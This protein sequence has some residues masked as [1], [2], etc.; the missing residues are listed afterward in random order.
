MRR[1]RPRALR[2]WP[3][4]RGG[5]RLLFL[6]IDG[7]LNRF[8]TRPQPDAAGLAAWLDPVHL[9]PLNRALLATAARVVISSSWRVGKELAELAVLLGDFGVLAP[10]VGMTP[11][12]PRQSRAD[13]IAAWL[14]VRAAAPAAFAIVDDELV[15]E[16]GPLAPHLVRTSRLSGLTEEHVGPLVTRLSRP[17]G[18]S[19]TMLEA[20]GPAAAA[21]AAELALEVGP[22]HALHGARVQAISR[23]AGEDDVLF[24]VDGPGGPL[25]V[26]HLTW[27][28]TREHDARWPRTI[29]YATRW[30]FD[31][32]EL[33]EP[34][35]DESQRDDA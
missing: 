23:R 3:E 27:Q 5:E 17:L 21:A 26:V 9:P 4:P 33:D 22:A 20:G 12:L 32:A 25:A 1:G 7:V 35:R 18:P 8:E 14:A 16:D 34:E 15:I 6:D 30:R 11:V 10:V 24:E 31:D 19:W 28:G 13:E 29:T 2:D